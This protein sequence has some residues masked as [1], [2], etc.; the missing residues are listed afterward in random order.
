MQNI[1]V[2]QLIMEDFII[3]LLSIYWD[4]YFPYEWPLNPKIDTA[5]WAFLGLSDMRHGL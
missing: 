1:T 3:N 4:L 5:T 2:I